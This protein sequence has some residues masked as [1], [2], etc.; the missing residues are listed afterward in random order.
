MTLLVPGKP[1]RKREF[2]GTQAVWGIAIKCSKI[3]GLLQLNISFISGT[4]NRE[5]KV[6]Q[7]TV[8]N[9]LFLKC[10]LTL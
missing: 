8:K 5:G 10:R 6:I 4:I 1:Y 2:W 9:I 7:D 3:L